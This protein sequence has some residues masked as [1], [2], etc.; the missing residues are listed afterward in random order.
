MEGF[1]MLNV[2]M[3]ML[4]VKTLIL[5]RLLWYQDMCYVVIS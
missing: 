4:D 3:E 2:G 1:M 5:M